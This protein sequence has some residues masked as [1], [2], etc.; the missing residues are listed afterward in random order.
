MQF[1]GRRPPDVQGD[2]AE[3]VLPQA[4]QLA[5]AGPGG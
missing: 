5:A 3:P 1:A 4:E 2:E